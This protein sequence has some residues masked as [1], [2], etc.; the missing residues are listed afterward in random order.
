MGVAKSSFI[1]NE[2]LF[3][4]ALITSVVGA[5][6]NIG[7]NY[8]LIP[9]LKAG[10][11]ILATIGSFFVSIFLMDLFFRDTRKN[12]GWMMKGMA[13]FWRIHRVN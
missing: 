2:N 10:G 6:L 3:R 12:F 13:T 5:G 1:T 7:M 8:F 11:A 9:E 4:Y